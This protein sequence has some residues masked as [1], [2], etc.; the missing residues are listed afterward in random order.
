M[1]QFNTKLDK[2]KRRQKRFYLVAGIPV[3]ATVLLILVLFI[4]SRGTRLE[5]LPVDAAEHAIIKVVEGLGFSVGETVYSL[6]G[7]PVITVA[8]P[9]FKVAKKKIGPA[10]L[11]KVFP[12]EL[13][14]LPGQLVVEIVGD[15]KTLLQ[16]AWRIDGREVALTNRL[17]L[18]LEAGAY[19]VSIDNPF[20]QEKEVGVASTRG[21][22]TQL[23][24]E[25]QPVAGVLNIVSKP[26]GATVFLG[27]TKV[28]LT[29]LQ[30]KQIGGRYSLR[31]A[32]ENYIDTVE[33]I[34]ITRADP[35]VS[36]TYQLELK[37]AWLIAELKPKGG[38]LLVDGVQAEKLLQPLVLAATVEHR[39]T[40]MKAGYYSKSQSVIL[41]AGEE[42]RISFQLQ[43]ETGMVEMVSSPPA[44]VWI[45]DKE[46]R[47]SPV[48]MDLS[49]VA[50][51]ITFKKPGYRSVTKV[52]KAKGGTVQK[53][54]V[55]LLTEYQARL[56]EA[57]REYT[58]TAG[59]KLKLYVIG[60]R[61]TMGAPRSEKGQRAN[62][63]QRKIS[64]TKPF[65]VGLYEITNGQF[66]QFNPGKAGGI[67]DNPVTSVAWQEAAAFCNWLS[68]KEKLQ[69]F[70]TTAKGEV[71]GFNS[72][73]DGYRLLSEGEWEWLARKAGKSKQTLFPWGNET[74]LPPKT[75]N[76]AEE[77]ARGRVRFF[78]PNYND[79]YPGLAPTGRFNREAS[80]LYDMAGNVS[81]WVH[82]VYS[83]V[84]PA[85]AVVANPLGQQHGTSHVVKG[86]NWRSGTL[87]TLRPAFR[88]GL[89]GGRDDVGFRIGRYIYGGEN[90]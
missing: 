69:L 15:E 42:K 48:S 55:K 14:A 86:A 72:H 4:V 27:E 43:A 49:A 38:T 57:P 60:E 12:L 26:S 2:A 16:T 54:S 90:E 1:S 66:A 39:L 28:G 83:I 21:E 85:E 81:E 61:F 29:P 67:A 18:E 13:F 56:Q 41:A 32:H 63:F 89:S 20:Y 9:G 79:G 25:L 88:E 31:V 44:T 24:V 3:L 59:V 35:G 46:H 45:D 65:Y 62:E 77:S 51:T 76:V 47:V 52:V 74:V 11:G 19:T 40:Y 17:D 75:A 23:Q 64:L 5:V 6:A 84:P 70:Y 37:K 10:H 78:V 58:N 8:A 36:R 71:T 87:T 7:N 80:G 30:G 34:A 82:D 22:L 68:T 33:E 53:V 50:H 73:S